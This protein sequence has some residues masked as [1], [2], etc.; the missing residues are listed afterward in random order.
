MK[1]AALALG[2]LVAMTGCMSMTGGYPFGGLYTGV[3]T[4]DQALDRVE[5]GGAGK[6]DDKTGEACAS[7]ILALIAWGDAS[8]D[9]AKKAGG[10]TEVHAVD[11]HTMSIL[12][13]VY[14][15]GCT[16]VRGK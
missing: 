15:S 12:G 10:I 7:G 14:A 11:H 6:T 4:P 8:L 3:G 5:V 13:F 1:I 16:I 2:S 9:A